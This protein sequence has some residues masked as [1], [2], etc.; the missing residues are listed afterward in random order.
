MRSIPFK[1]ICCVGMNDASFPRTTFLPS[2]NLIAAHPRKGDR[3]LE[4]EDR[5]L[6][7]EALL[8]ARERLFISFCGQSVRD[9]RDAVPSVVVQELLACID[10]GFFSD[11]ID[12]TGDRATKKARDIVLVRHRLQPWSRAYFTGNDRLFTYSKTNRQAAAAFASSHVSA[13]VHEFRTQTLLPLSDDHGD[14]PLDSLIAFLKHPARFFCER[15]LGMVLDSHEEALEENECFT[16]TGL[17]KYRLSQ[18][19]VERFLDRG[20]S[21][22]AFRR[23][24]AEGSLPHGAIGDSQ[25]DALA[26]EARHFAE[27]IAPRVSRESAKPDISIDM[28]V[29]SYRVTGVINGNFDV[30]HIRYRYSPNTLPDLLALWVEH[31]VL[32]I[33][34]PMPSFFFGK[35]ERWRFDPPTDPQGDL[36]RIIELYHEDLTRPL[37]FFPKTSFA[38]ADRVI[39]KEM[40]AKTAFDRAL[41]SWRGSDY[42]P[43][44]QEDPW[45][46]FCFKGHLAHDEYF[47]RPA[48]TVWKSLFNCLRKGEL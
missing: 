36:L 3:S 43:G 1:V 31:C 6:F 10:N 47:I 32:T 20:T 41:E 25:F 8:S 48:L 2:W 22:E 33:R 14:I 17:E 7:L 46:W 44:E 28:P 5:Y 21:Q 13:A 19:L 18:E 42:A 12:A 38:Y 29:G 40:E 26:A 30:G 39:R 37:C 15:R 24:S 34:S 4:R 23:F 45:N 27:S 35:D 11:D 16:L 9:N